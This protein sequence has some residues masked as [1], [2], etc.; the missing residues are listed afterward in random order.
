MDS[1]KFY[2]K[3]EKSPFSS[4]ININV[5]PL[6]EKPSL[7]SK[8]K[9]FVNANTD[10]VFMF[11]TLA[12]LFSSVLIFANQYASTQKFARGLYVDQNLTRFLDGKITL[13]DIEI[14][15]KLGDSKGYMQ[16]WKYYQKH[17]SE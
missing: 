2:T 12:L 15:Q 11:V 1:T 9:S 16:D 5:N 14:L 7:S 13:N 4:M 17:K 10:A 6:A 8:V 3:K